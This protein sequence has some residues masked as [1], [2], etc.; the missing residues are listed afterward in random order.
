MFETATFDVPYQPP[1]IPVGPITTRFAPAGRNAEG[2]EPRTPFRESTA[3]NLCQTPAHL[4]ERLFALNP[5]QTLCRCR[6][7]GLVFNDRYRID[8]DVVY[9]EDYFENTQKSEA[10]GYYDYHQ[11]ESALNRDYRFA[12][13]F[14]M[15][16]A[17]GRPRP[18][19][20]LDVG[21][22]Y[23]FFLKQFAGRP[24]LTATGIELSLPAVERA[25]RHVAR[26]IHGSV[27][28][29]TVAKRFDVV[30]AFELLEHLLDPRAFMAK[31]AQLLSPRGYFL[32]TTPDIGNRWFSILRRRWPAIH[33]ACHNY[34][35]S[36]A[37]VSAVAQTAG[38]R[39]LSIRRRQVLHKQWSHL[40][41]RLGSLFPPLRPLLGP[42]KLMDHLLLPFLSGGSLE[43][44]LQKGESQP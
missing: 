21:C 39:V 22:G 8:L 29:L 13:R 42:T 33:P 11:L 4:A 3:C 44:I 32:L 6:K 12:Y 30:V 24:G 14:I 23:G 38:F 1:T 18:L 40:R 15:G 26:V 5:Q 25:R 16:N 37:T 2:G 36:Q 9:A 43:V 31:V 28:E 19:R 41:R 27:E 34:Y 20:L 35:F 10:G 17:A 7:C